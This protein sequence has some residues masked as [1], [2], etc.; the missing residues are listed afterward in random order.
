VPLAVFGALI[1]TFLKMPNPNMSYWTN[2]WT[3]TLNI[4][5][6]VGLITLVG[7]VSKNGILIV[8]FS[9]KLQEQGRDKVDAVYEAAMTRLCPILM[10]TFATVI[11][12]FPLT[13]IDGAGA[14]ARNSIGL[15]LVGGMFVGT[16][17]TLF[18]VPS[19]YVLIA[20]DKSKSQLDSYLADLSKS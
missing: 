12:Y 1:F 11:G 20:K 10:T 16:V 3:T 13:L 17:F 8:E 5:S 18:V 6:Q 7:L 19:I 14:A 9:N 4:Y 2:G 15:V